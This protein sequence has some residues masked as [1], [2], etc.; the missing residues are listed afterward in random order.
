MQSVVSLGDDDLGEDNKDG[1][2]ISVDKYI[3]ESTGEE[4]TQQTAFTLPGDAYRDKNYMDW[5]LSD[6]GGES[7][8]VDD[9][10][11]LMHQRHLRL[12][13]GGQMT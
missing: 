4:V 3:I 6:K 2:V 8:L 12:S 11:D 10:Q 9:Y 13:K 7:D 5:L 1:N